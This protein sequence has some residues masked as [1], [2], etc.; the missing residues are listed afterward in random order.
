MFTAEVDKVH[1]H[2]TNKLRAKR[3]ARAVEL[4]ASFAKKASRKIG[5]KDDF[6]SFLNKWKA[7]EKTT[8]GHGLSV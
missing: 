1:T 6:N 5:S 3:D 7:L 2:K 8:K 4:L